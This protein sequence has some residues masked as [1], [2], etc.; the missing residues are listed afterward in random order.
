LSK[1]AHGRPAAA[2]QAA[3]DG[4]NPAN[5]LAAAVDLLDEEPE[6]IDDF[7]LWL[8]P[9]GVLAF[10]VSDRVVKRRV[11]RTRDC[12]QYGSDRQRIEGCSRRKNE[13]T[14]RLFRQG[15]VSFATIPAARPSSESR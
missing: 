6:V 3:G 8:A 14:R 5:H 2:R 1:R 4:R 9:A 11:D 15:V 12:L 13:A 10:C 7:Q